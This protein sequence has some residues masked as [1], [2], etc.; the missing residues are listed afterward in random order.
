MGIG[1]KGL[2]KRKKGNEE[3]D[4]I[5]C[6]NIYLSDDRIR[7]EEAFHSIRM[8]RMSFWHIITI[9]HKDGELFNIYSARELRLPFYN[10]KS[11]VVCGIARGA[12]A[13]VELLSRMLSDMYHDT[14]AFDVNDYF[15]P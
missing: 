15:H 9:S 10:G 13:S 11:F 7:I 8:G 2:L 14:R 6:E 3:L 4:L 1:I 5:P 12:N